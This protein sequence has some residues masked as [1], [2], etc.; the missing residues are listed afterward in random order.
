MADLDTFES[1]PKGCADATVTP[2]RRVRASSVRGGSTP[3][4]RLSRPAEHEVSTRW[5][6]VQVGRLKKRRRQSTVIASDA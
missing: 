4:L 6:I 5:N 1:R 2:D 3:P